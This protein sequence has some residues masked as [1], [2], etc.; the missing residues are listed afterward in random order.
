[1]TKI[2]KRV[3]KLLFVILSLSY[4]SSCF[5]QAI[6]PEFK[7]AEQSAKAQDYNK[8][9][10]HFGR[11]LLKMP[12]TELALTSAEEASQIALLKTQDYQSAIEFL[13][14]IVLHSKNEKQRHQAQEKMAFVYLERMNLFEKA[15][16]EYSRLVA[17]PILATQ[18]V[19]YRYKIAKAFYYL[20]KFDQ[21]LLELSDILDEEISKEQRFTLS[22]FKANVLLTQKRT[23]EAIVELNKL[24][25]S[26]PERSK[27]EK[28]RFMI[29]VAYEDQN[30][31][32][33]AVE[34][35]NEIKMEYDDPE[36]IDIKIKRLTERMANQPGRK[37]KKI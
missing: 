27:E 6:D 20:N 12:D 13:K 7:L 2:K 15:I 30:E 32:D 11:V 5:Y 4:L 14:Y 35:L 34:I 26:F 37:K 23:D 28:I 31:F 29:A 22:L 33:K 25:I 24:H 1:M 9:I 17:L 10:K 19:E 21:A 3:S 18:K 16:E 36:F 8:A